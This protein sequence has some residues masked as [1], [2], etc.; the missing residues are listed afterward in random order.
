MLRLAVSVACAVEGALSGELRPDR[1]RALGPRL[2][3]CTDGGGDEDGAPRFGAFPAETLH[4]H[5]H[6]EEPGETERL[7]VATRFEVATQAL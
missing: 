3:D 2:F 5:R 1:S 4:A 6:A 7:D